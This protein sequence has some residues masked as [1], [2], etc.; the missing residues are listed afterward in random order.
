MTASLGA[1]DPG[2]GTDDGGRLTVA[3]S[4]YPVFE[5]AT[6]VGG[7][8]VEVSNLTPPG[9]EPHDLELT[10][11][12]VDAVLDAD[13]VIHL[14]GG[15]QPALADALEGRDGPVLDLLTEVLG[16]DA[17]GG[18]VDPHVWL[19]PALMSIAAAEVGEALSLV[20][21]ANAGYYRPRARE[22]QDELGALDS[23]MRLGLRGCERDLIVTAHDA[24]G[25]LALRY[26]LRVEAIAGIS[27]EAEPDPARLE[28]LIRLVEREHVTTI[29]TETLV[30]P[31]VAETLAR[32]AGV[33]TAVL[34]P[35]EGLTEAEREAGEDYFSLMR[36]NLGELRAALG[37]P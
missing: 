17:E 9:A 25:R 23:E 3:A 36:A 31:E 14:G 1:C 7:D 20:D 19:D 10:T 33:R 8:R 29:F 32:E 2:P 22:F 18:D 21:D 27:P 6:R 24:F 35:M 28:E 4:F 13:L 30:S 12:Q 37:C 11:D 5:L 26:G 15:F 34:N 16:E